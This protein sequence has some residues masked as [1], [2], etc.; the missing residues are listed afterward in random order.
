MLVHLFELSCTYVG[1]CGLS[2]TSQQQESTRL[3]GLLS[4]W[5]ISGEL[6]EPKQNVLHLK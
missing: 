2:Q 6:D 3:M 4:R 1:C 5:K